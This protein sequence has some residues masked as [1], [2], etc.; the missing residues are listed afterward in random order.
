MALKTINDLTAL[1]T[2]AS[3]DLIGVWNV[4]A[5]RMRKSTLAQVVTQSGVAA[6]LASA[7]TFTAKQTITGHTTG[8]GLAVNLT[9]PGGNYNTIEAGN[10]DNTSSTGPRLLLGYNNNGSTPAAGSIAMRNLAGSG[11]IIW[12]DASGNLRIHSSAPTNA[13]DTA[14]TVVGA[15]T[16]HAS[17]KD[18]VGA[19][20]ADDAALGHVVAAAA[21]VRRFRY[22]SGAF[23]SQEF[24]GVVLDGPALH[25]YGEDADAEH[26]AGKTLNVVNAIGDLLL[27]VREV[28]RRLTALE[29]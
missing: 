18:V 23:G 21:D 6:L 12:P 19:P 11:Y 4:S 14:G 29:A 1:T 5:G 22:K 17:Y 8:V 24:S 3:T 20:V 15:Q 10:F 26:P 16:S 9:T 2:P 13:T 25:R 27:A 28:N 7:N